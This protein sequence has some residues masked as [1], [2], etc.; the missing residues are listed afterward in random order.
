MTASRT[1]HDDIDLLGGL[2]GEVIQA[3]EPMQAFVLEERARALGKA[4]RSGDDAAREQLSALV[5]SLSIDEATVLVRAFT[6]YFR[7]VNLAEDSERVRRVRAREREVLPAA[8]RGSLREA[9]E[10]IAARGTSAEA[11][12]ELL[13]QAEIRLVLTAHP[14]E[15]RR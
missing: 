13:A 9:I 6:S 5:A 3:Q 1:L 12:Q 7:L 11:L 15:A 2:L 14:T 10:I 8:R 4:L